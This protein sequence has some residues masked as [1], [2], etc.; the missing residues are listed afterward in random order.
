M[1]ARHTG[2]RPQAA[3]ER[4]AETPGAPLAD[5]ELARADEELKPV[6][7]GGLQIGGMAFRRIQSPLAACPWKTSPLPPL[8]LLMPDA[9][10]KREPTTGSSGGNRELEGDVMVLQ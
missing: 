2:L 1:N 8:A 7:I 5:T 3:P 9:L 6:A 10:L 4:L